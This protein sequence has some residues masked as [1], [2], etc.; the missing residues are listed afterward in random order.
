MV[1]QNQTIQALQEALRHSPDNIPLRQ[2]LAEL[3]AGQGILDEAEK[4]FRQALLQAPDNPGLKIGL[5]QVFF[6]LG[7]TSQALV[8]VED[9]LRD[10]NPPARAFLLNARLLHKI[11]SVQ[12]SLS[13]YRAAIAAD[14]AIADP[15]FASQLGLG[16]TEGGG[17][18]LENPR[19]GLATP[20]L[21][22]LGGLQ[23][24]PRL[25]FQDV[26]G[27]DKVKEEIRLK[28]LYPLLHPQLYQAYGKTIG[29]GILLY[30]PPGCGKTHLARA[31]AGEVKGDFLAVGIHEVLD[32]WIGQ[33]ERNLH[34]FFEQARRRRPCVLFFDEVDALGANRSDLRTNTGRPLIN[35]FLAEM[36]GVQNSNEGV[37][38][39][40]AT[41][42]P[43]H[44]DPAFRRPG[45]FDRIIF[46]PPPDMAARATI[47][48]ILCRG[49]PV[50]DIDFQ[51]LSRKMDGFSGADLKM[52]LDL[53]VENKL[54][55]ALG[56]GVLRPLTTRDL[57]EVANLMRPSTQEWFATARN[58]ALYANQGGIYDDVIK[59][60]KM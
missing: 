33:G 49:K 59:Y 9:L 52:V 8:V 25:N 2:H 21:E 22:D 45:R 34:E 7:K 58:H 12:E 44:M 39:M 40:A 29:G 36:D 37:L 4:E 15:D 42:A 1:N 55:Q 16:A 31:T 18:V 28:I 30:G 11:G 56:D 51:A 46:V 48:R 60:L 19:G 50:Q 27:M 54:R 57:H 6:Q 47:L 23:E 41:N 24:R 5:A 35:Q 38:I 17:A 20:S 53:T 14:P 43:W 32:M 26:G 10:P 13:Q 3:L